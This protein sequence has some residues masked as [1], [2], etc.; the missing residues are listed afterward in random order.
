MAV[1]GNMNAVLKDLTAIAE[2]EINQTQPEL[3]PLICSTV[4][5]DG[6]YTRIPIE[7]TI[8]FMRKFEGERDAKGK[9]V[10]VVMNYNQDTY[11]L[12][13][14]LDSDHLM[15]AK[16]YSLSDLVKEATMSAKL[17]PSYLSSQMVINGA[18]LNAYDGN[19]FYGHTH[20][21]AKTGANNIDNLL[22]RTSSTVDGIATDL[23]NAA[24][25]IQTA[26]DNQGRLLNPLA[27]EGIGKMLIHC[28][29]S[30]NKAMR[31][32]LHGSI[33]PI[34]AT[35]T[36]SGTAAVSGSNVAWDAMGDIYPDGYLDAN[37]KTTW[38]L[39]YVGMPRK[40]FVYI[41]NYG[42]RLDVL[43]YGSEFQINNKKVRIALSRRFVMGY[44][45][46]DRSCKIA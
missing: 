29:V 11:E 19:P 24:A 30:L 14:D 18:T 12:T 34:K 23:A 26:Q 25:V 32:V 8:A 27:S 28:P 41:E 7:S 3:H 22:T 5:E 9:D 20:T 1:V 39:H 21:Y 36:T 46:F 17:F 37:S 15:N 44:N 13:I 33:I 42:L 38:Y 2:D 43:G 31:T 35:V 45:R 40:P 16:A 6:S 10:P 4:P